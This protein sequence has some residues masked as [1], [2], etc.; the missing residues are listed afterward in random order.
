[1][2]ALGIGCRRNAPTEDIEALIAQ[3]LVVAALSVD[4]VDVI[5]TERGKVTEPGLIEAARQLDRRLVGFDASELAGVSDL[6]VTVSERVQ[7]LKGVPSV[8][9][10]AALTAVGRDARLVVPRVANATVTCALA[11][12]EGPFA[13]EKGA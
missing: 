11:Y 2:I 9:E 3:V 10:T 4:D 12:G 7:A 8:A 1:M 6:A 5:A 13:L